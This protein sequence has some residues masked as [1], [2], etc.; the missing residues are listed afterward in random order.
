V[1][2]AR[3]PLHPV[4]GLLVAVLPALGACGRPIAEDS[5]ASRAPLVEAVPARFGSLPVEE[6]VPGVVRARNQ[7][8]IRPE[9][10]AR[11]IEV[12]VRSGATD[13]RGDLL[14]RL[15]PADRARFERLWP[16]ASFVPSA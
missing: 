3:H 5:V 16:E 15:D 6:T 13:E 9:I 11:V 10:E 7:V 2:D 14:V 1:I 12:R 4:C 8:A